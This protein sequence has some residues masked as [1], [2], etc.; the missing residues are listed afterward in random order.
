MI[1]TQQRLYRNAVISYVDILGFSE[2]IKESAVTP[3]RVGKIAD[4][5][6]AVRDELGFNP[7]IQKSKEPARTP[8]FVSEIFSDL[9]I[10]TRFV[11][12]VSCQKE[13][14]QELGYLASTQ[15][16]LAV[17]EDV[18]IRGGVCRGTIVASDNVTFGPGLVKSYRLESEYALYPRIVV[19][20]DLA[21]ELLNDDPHEEAGRL[22]RR[23][24]DGAYFVD[25]LF[26]T[27]S[28]DLWVD[29]WRDACEKLRM[30]RDFVLK[31]LQDNISKQPETVKQKLIWLGIYHNAAIERLATYKYTNHHAERMQE[32]KLDEQQLRF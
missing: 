13:A 14:I 9:T 25:Y 12:G 3:E 23:A 10:R 16:N 32:C 24:E 21:F 28:G 26:L 6:Q 22:L 18:L 20:R 7:R 5:L 19:D 30:H 2:M 1:E 8:T 29:E 17:S 31:R 27:A 11:A 15:F 4:L